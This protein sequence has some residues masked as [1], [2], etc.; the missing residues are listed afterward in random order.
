MGFGQDASADSVET[1]STD[2]SK[3]ALSATSFSPVLASTQDS[4][5]ENPVQEDVDINTSSNALIP[6]TGSMG[7]NPSESEDLDA[8]QISVY[9]VRKN[10]SIGAIAK[11]FDVSPNTI[12]WANGIKKGDKLVEG[13]TLIILPTSGIKVVVSKGQTLKG[14]ATKYKADVADIASFNGIAEDAALAV[15]DEL[16]IPDGEIVDSSEN[17]PSKNIVYTETSTGSSNG[18]FIK[19]IPCPYTQGKH[20]RYAIDLSCH[21]VGTPIKAAAS[22]TVIFSKDGYN[23]GFGNLVIIK[24]NNGS[25]TFYAHQS[26]RA[27][28]QGEYVTQGQIIGYVGS[29]GH[30]TGPHLHFEVRG[31]KNPGF[32]MSGKSWKKQ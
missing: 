11:M 2:N 18:Y 27:I 5:D 9:V 3:T 24:H 10:D 29:T 28:G 22:G 4:K 14:L 31:A 7:A 23:G 25:Q 26:R 15:G 20:D 19:P 1:I 17:K 8:D 6:S 21:T 32:D 30:S 12:L 13:D 16:I